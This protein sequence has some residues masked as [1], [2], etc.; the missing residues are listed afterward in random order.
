MHFLLFLKKRDVLN[1]TKQSRDS[2]RIDNNRLKQ[3]SGLLGNTKLLRDFEECVDRNQT[4][5]T[6]I[7]QLKRRHA[8]LILDS[9]GLK[10]KISQV[11]AD[12]K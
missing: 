5:E 12:A 6:E 11:K 4:L 2:L 10:N 3:S 8:E 1:H 7:E 9:K